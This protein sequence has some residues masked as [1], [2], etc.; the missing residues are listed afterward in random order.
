MPAAYD[1]P[2]IA[3]NDITMTSSPTEAPSGDYDRMA[4]RTNPLEAFDMRDVSDNRLASTT[5]FFNHYAT[6]N[7]RLQHCVQPF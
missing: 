3:S 2:N 4:I 6:S 5:V 7:N 1:K